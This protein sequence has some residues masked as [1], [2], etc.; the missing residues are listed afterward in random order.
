ME[1]R[2]YLVI[3]QK[4][5]YASVECVERGLDPMTAN[6]V[7]ADPE[8]SEKTVCLAVSPAMKAKGVKG[9]CRVFEIP[10][11]I[12]YIMAPPR[13]RLY[14]DYAVRIYK[15]YLQ[16]LA[17][18]DIH[19]YS[20]DEAFL[21][22]THYLSY[23]GKP[24]REL[25]QEI[26]AA[27]LSQTGIRAA[28]GIGTNL[29]LAKIALDITAKHADDFI[30]ELDEESYCR[31]LWDHR[32]LTDFW[33]VGAGTARRLEKYGICTMRQI[34]QAE[35]EFLYRLFGVD[36][37]LLIDHAWGR[38]SVTMEDI[39]RYQ[40]SS[41]S[42]SS[43][44]V[45]PHNYDFR[46][47]ELIVKEMA[48]ALCLD[49]TERGAGVGSV[50][51]YLGYDRRQGIPSAKGAVRLDR[52]ACSGAE[53][54][55][56]VVELYRRIAARDGMLRRVNLTAQNLIAVE[57]LAFYEQESLFDDTEARR[58]AERQRT[59]QRTV[60]EVR[61][62]FGKNAV[63]KGMNFL[64]GSTMRERNGQIG[65]HKSGETEN[66]TG[67]SREAVSAVRRAARVE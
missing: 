53:L 33:R 2:V 67:K 36:A 28:C 61:R 54:I 52:P 66:V 29:Y 40:P 8:R 16:Y 56:A 24:A 62:R 22:V 26:M 45:L 9:R 12:D 19:I 39:K 15:I 7:V 32:P 59:L 14:M 23:Y 44:Q 34:A 57:D 47:G 6:L 64:E 46:G 49:L 42:M 13:M 38:E 3:D 37:E 65:G 21:D 30:G 20:V 31:T 60:V 4:S 43:G 55:P 63:L 51:L 50:G 17:P 58:R 27:I 41:C 5:F 35:E 11:Y 25:G 10:G 1:Q 18:C 48:D